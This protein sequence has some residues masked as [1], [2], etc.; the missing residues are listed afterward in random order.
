MTEAHRHPAAVVLVAGQNQRR[1][2]EEWGRTGDAK[3]QICS[4][5]PLRQCPCLYWKHCR[6]DSF[7]RPCSLHKLP[8]VSFIKD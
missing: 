2:D 6:S 5:A 8:F 4:L 3:E 7:C 1:S